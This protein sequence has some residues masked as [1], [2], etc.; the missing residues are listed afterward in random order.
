MLKFETQLNILSI[1]LLVDCRLILFLK[2]STY[3]CYGLKYAF[4]IFF[5]RNMHF[6]DFYVLKFCINI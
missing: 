4:Y 1:V 2:Y 6:V 3:L 5:S